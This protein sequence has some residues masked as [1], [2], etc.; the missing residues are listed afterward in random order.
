MGKGSGSVTAFSRADGFVRIGRNTEI[1]DAESQVDVTLLG[2]E[3]PGGRISWSS[4]VTAWG[5]THRERPGA[6]GALRIKLLAVGSQGG[7]W[8][9]RSAASAT[10]RPSTCWI[11]ETGRY[12]EPFLTEGLRLLPGYRAHARAS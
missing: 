6:R 12:N 9:Q 10:S 2:R 8:R 5:S 4:A 1:V 11:A 3:T 7:S